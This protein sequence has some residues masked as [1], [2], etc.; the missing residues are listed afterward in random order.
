MS[1]VGSVGIVGMDDLFS[2]VGLVHL[3]GSVNS[4]FIRLFCS[5]SCGVGCEMIR[6]VML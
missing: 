4:L 2:S 6:Y 1:L 5:E 3:F